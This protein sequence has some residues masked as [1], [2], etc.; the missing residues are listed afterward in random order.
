MKQIVF[1]TQNAHKVEEIR[2]ALNNQLN[3]VTL[4]EAGVFIDIPEPF[5][6]LE[7]NAAEK[8]R[9]VHQLTGKD[10]FGEDTGLEV[11][12]L[13]GEPG[14]KSAR[15]AGEERDSTRNVEKLLKKMEGKANRKAHFRTSIAL[16]LEGK[17]Y[18]FEGICEG[19]I[20]DHPRGHKGFGYDPVFRPAGA[21]K[22]FGEMDILEK[23]HYSH[24]RKAVDQLVNFLNGKTRTDPS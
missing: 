16:V 5:D 18:Q 22:S 24:R 23:N 1:A 17:T 9:V 21:T 2:A 7:E 11:D 13:S 4:A 3:I 6:T 10:C 19:E 15:Y 20:L 8:A 14:A 12:A